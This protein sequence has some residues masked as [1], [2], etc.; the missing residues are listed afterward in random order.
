MSKINR[1]MVPG[2][3]ALAALVAIGLAG[4]ASA[5]HDGSVG[6]CDGCHSMHNSP[7]N[8]IDNDATENALLL[9]GN[10]PSST[11]LNCH[12]GPG[13]PTSYHILSSDGTAQ[14]PGGDFFWVATSY[15]TWA[16]T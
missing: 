1:L 2:I 16:T 11:C 14:S 6:Y 9:K 3:T 13:S 12:A 15:A 7:D 8:P 5:F 10:G 4:T